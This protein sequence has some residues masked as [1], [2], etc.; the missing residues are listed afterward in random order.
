[1]SEPIPSWK[2]WHPLPIWQV[3]VCFV[4]VELSLTFL[5]VALREVAGIVVPFENVIVGGG[6]GLLGFALVIVLRQRQLA[7]ASKD[8]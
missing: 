5:V 1:M 4:V 8:T 6:G 3:I 2:F 7:G